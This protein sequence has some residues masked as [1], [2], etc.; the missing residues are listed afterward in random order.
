MER[1]GFGRIRENERDREIDEQENLESKINH[2]ESLEKRDA[3]DPD[4]ERRISS[5]VTKARIS[6]ALDSVEERENDERRTNEKLEEF[7]RD[8]SKKLITPE[9]R[10]KILSN[11]HAEL[12]AKGELV[13]EIDA[14]EPTTETGEEPLCVDTSER[15]QDAL[16]N[17]PELR[18]RKRITEE[19]QDV[20]E[21]YEN[22][23]NRNPPTL[24][25][26]VEYLETRRLY[27]EAND[28]PPAVEIDSMDDVERLLQKHSSERERKNFS[29]QYENTRIYFEVRNDQTRLQRELAEDYGVSQQRISEYQRG[30]ETTLISNLRQCEEDVIVK[31]WASSELH[32]YLENKEKNERESEIHI[33]EGTELPSGPS[34]HR[35]ESFKVKEHL[36][37][38]LETNSLNEFVDGIK[39]GFQELIESGARVGYIETSTITKITEIAKMNCEAIEVDLRKHLWLEPHDKSVRI[40][41]TDERVYIW[42]PDLTPDDMINPWG[43]QYFY[44]K[45]KDL[46]RIFIEVGNKLEM[47]K[48]DYERLTHYNELVHQIVS[49]K[50]ADKVNLKDDVTRIQGDNLHLVSEVM[51]VS[52]RSFED[53][54][55]K[56]ASYNGQS[57]IFNPKILNGQRLEELRADFVATVLS[58]CALSKEG[59]LKYY[60]GNLD[61][62]NIVIKNL[63][64]FGEFNV[65]LRYLADDNLYEMTFPRPFGKAALYWEVPYGDKT[66]Q[67]P[68]IPSIIE[69]G[70]FS[71]TKSYLGGLIPEE[72]GVED[73]VLWKRSNAVDAGIKSKEYDFEPKIS[74]KE[75][76]LII[77]KGRRDPKDFEGKIYLRWSDIDDIMKSNSPES[78]TA[79][80]L[81]HTF[82]ENPNNLM[83]GEKRIANNLGIKIRIVPETVS[84]YEKTGRVSLKWKAHTYRIEDTIRWGIMS[85]PNDIRKKEKMREILLKRQDKVTEIC[86]DIKK[87]GFEFN[88]WWTAKDE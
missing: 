40:G 28:G 69:T 84:F 72:G 71:G 2:R 65:N 31:E 17:H 53:R 51:G 48:N 20:Q 68:E 29:D 8:Y 54:I 74:R 49:D 58:D 57:C 62:I 45:T 4:L 38:S 70:S 59:R 83:R 34:I 39:E 85:P 46:A 19:E 76:N 81:S 7:L 5:I 63:N 1:S 75:I 80:K 3:Q 13:S 41:I 25:R 33:H 42:R 87:Q 6:D 77:S 12:A 36:E 55:L 82:L 18:F 26:E 50:Y 22:G 73:R 79:E 61:R 27:E 44:F 21:F 11:Y 47:G 15:F 30:V 60:E 9:E 88:E 67:N 10:D 43:N 78:S 24:V 52:P 56:V 32:Q 64:E 66:I 86:E 35:I 23:E 16:K 37:K 14:I